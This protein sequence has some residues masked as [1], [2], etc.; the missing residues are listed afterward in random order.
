MNRYISKLSDEILEEIVLENGRNKYFKSF[1]KN[2]TRGTFIKP[3]K[4]MFIIMVQII[5][6]I[7]I[8]IFTIIIM[9]IK[10]VIPSA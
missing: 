2:F 3:A 9:I 6:I 1:S 5:I 10:Y 8:Y 4:Q 7:Y